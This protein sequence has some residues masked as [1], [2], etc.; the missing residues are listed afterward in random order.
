MSNDSG[1]TYDAATDTM[2]LAGDLWWQSGTAFLGKFA[3]AI[4]AERTWTFPDLAGTVV[5][6][7][8]SQDIDNN[9]RVAVR[10]NTGG[11]DVGERRR[12][13]FIEGSNITL[14]ISDDGASEEVDIQI[15]GTT[16]PGTGE[17]NATRLY[18]FQQFN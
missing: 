12:L 9:A 10:K 6:N 15:A 5:V 1:M 7:S 8:T 11:A 4:S 3:H 14:T 13:N 2:T 16:T 18:K 17:H